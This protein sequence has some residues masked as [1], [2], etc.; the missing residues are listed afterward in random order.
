MR[1]G[2]LGLG[3][4]PFAPQFAERRLRSRSSE[5]S[6]TAHKK[7]QL[8]SL[9]RLGA[10]YLHSGSESIS[11]FVINR[12]KPPKT[13]N[14]VLLCLRSA[15]GGGGGTAVVPWAHAYGEGFKYEQGG[16]RCV[17]V[18]RSPDLIYY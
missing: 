16:I 15:V 1:C 3:S 13:G 18:S 9:A 7:N 4:A 14:Y 12:E 11:P 5:E 10:K 17:S 6:I 2:F 8:P